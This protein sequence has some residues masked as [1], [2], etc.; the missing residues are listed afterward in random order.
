[1]IDDDA[2]IEFGQPADDIA[3]R[4]SLL[5]KPE[6][7]KSLAEHMRIVKLLCK[8]VLPKLFGEGNYKM[9]VA[10]SYNGV[11]LS[12]T[13]DKKHLDRFVSEEAVLSIEQHCPDGLNDV[14]QRTLLAVSCMLKRM[15]TKSDAYNDHKL[16]NECWTYDNS[17]SQCETIH[18]QPVVSGF[19]GCSV[20]S[21]V[22]IHQVLH[23]P[24]L[25]TLDDVRK[26]LEN[27]GNE[28]KP[29]KD[30]CKARAAG[31]KPSRKLETEKCKAK[32]S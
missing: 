1:M 24:D 9:D 28:E 13:C 17:L 3:R 20:M 18:K 27:A 6:L 21:D 22:V 29:A 14:K 2:K 15:F 5:S 32:K 25:K 8:R 7:K 23:C 11:M 12:F 31:V 26:H 19:N 4:V 16:I 10:D 30:A